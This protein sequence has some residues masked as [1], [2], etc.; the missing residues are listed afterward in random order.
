MSPDGRTGVAARGTPVVAL[1]ADC[2][3]G[4]KHEGRLMIFGSPMTDGLRRQ[5]SER[6]DVPHFLA[7]TTPTQYP[8]GEQL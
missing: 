3:S 7:P 8:S 1:D 6:M 2:S 4:A 5:A